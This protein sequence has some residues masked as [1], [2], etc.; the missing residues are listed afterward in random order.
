MSVRYVYSACLVIETPDITIATDPWFTPG[1][2][3]GSWVQYPPLERDPHEC[4]GPVDAIYVSHIHPDHYDPAFLHQYLRRTP[5][6][7]LWVGPTSSPFLQRKMVSDGFKPRLVERIRV[8][9]TSIS[10]VAN[11]AIEDDIDTALVVANDKYSVVNMND[12]PFDENQVKEIRSLC[13]AGRPTA[14]FFPYSPAGPWPQT[15]DYEPAEMA[16]K[17]AYMKTRF[18]ELYCQYVDEFDPDVAMPFA[19][20]YVLAGPL[21]KL[22]G[23]RGTS[24]AT[25][26]AQARPANSLVLSDGGQ[27]EI[28]LETLEATS[29]RGAPY[30]AAEVDRYLDEYAFPGYDYEREIAR[31]DRRRLP[32]GLILPL[33]VD[34]ARRRWPIE[35]S[36]WLCI[37]DDD[38]STY[39][40]FDVAADEAP[41]ALEAV[42]HLFPRLEIRVDERHLFGL[43]TRLY[44]WN[45][46]EIGSH[47]RFAR[48]PDVY[49]RD[50]HSFLA[51]LHV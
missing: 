51:R 22:N 8:G 32:I 50:V 43:L 17:S 3:D 33:A 1:A 40:A 20:Q 23:H 14:G 10:A 9:D 42:G 4:L 18:L 39:H 36:C 24:D 25:E 34:A 16:A 30:S 27:S 12:N 15:F 41:S 44:H 2:F 35:E 49:R 19:G 46:A 13:P 11:R 29:L 37:S 48:R 6:T 7:E 26:A 28:D 31:I 38:G 47:L 45:N 5:Q 21:R